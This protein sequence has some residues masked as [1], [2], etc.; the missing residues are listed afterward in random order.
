MKWKGY[1]LDN[2]CDRFHILP[3]FTRQLPYNGKE[4]LS[5]CEI[6]KYF[7]AKNLPIID[8]N[9]L[10]SIKSMSDNDWQRYVEKIQGTLVTNPAKRPS[11]LRLDQLDRDYLKNNLSSSTYPLI[12][13][14]NMFRNSWLPMIKN[15]FKLKKVYHKY[16]KLRHL[17][18]NKPKLSEE[19]KAKLRKLSD[20]LQTLMKKNTEVQKEDMIEINSEGF[21]CTG[22]RTDIV[23]H[24]VL[25]PTFIEHL[26]FHLSIRHLEEKIGYKFKDRLNLQHAL[27]HPSGAF[28][29]HQNLGSN[30][31][32]IRNVLYNCRPRNPNYG[33]LTPHKRK[34]ILR[35]KGIHVLF[36]IMSY[37][38][39]ET[40]ELSCVSNYERLEFLGDKILELLISKHLF[41]LFPMFDEGNLSEY[42]NCIVQNQYLAVLAKKLDLHFFIIFYH[43]VDLCS[44][45]ALNHALAN[46]FEALLAAIFLDSNLD[47]VS[48][49]LT[50]ILWDDNDLKSIWSEIPLHPIQAQLPQGDRYLIESTEILQQVQKFEETIGV[51][52]NHIRLLAQALCTRSAS[53]NLITLGDNQ[54]LEFLGD[55]VLN[56]IVSNYLYRYFPMHHEGHLS[57]LRSSLVCNSTQALLYDELGMGQYILS[58]SVNSKPDNNGN[59]KRK[60]DVFEAFIGALYI[61]QGLQSVEVFCNVC[62]FNKLQDIIMYQFWNDPKSRLQQCCLSLRDVDDSNPSLPTYKLIEERGPP[63]RKQYRV[64][65]YFKRQRIGEGIGKSIHEGEVEAAKNAL[66][67]QAHMFPILNK[68]VS[69]N[70]SKIKVKDKIFENIQ[71]ELEDGE[72]SSSSESENGD[73]KK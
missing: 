73:A 32:H 42:R 10:S 36:S 3:R 22:I 64:A 28:L 35:K 67:T 54:R 33:D 48:Q 68:Y 18:N 20:E 30:P 53:F 9:L 19:D 39:H 66:K 44:N 34:S 47:T 49:I 26:R 65:V 16:F 57:L 4:I 2:S 46:S 59:L 31:D 51:E 25:I 5:P 37:K 1:G 62:M 14:F 8:Q 61:D 11:A 38:A 70:E 71:R 43:G 7:L 55:T 27:T 21:Y 6:M 24:A 60:A 50:K 69:N 45:A 52:F 13:H 15:D 63:N 41:F 72:C 23:Q 29:L 58:H 40:E 12:I 56:F 17:L